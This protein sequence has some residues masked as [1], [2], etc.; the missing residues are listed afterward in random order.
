MKTPTLVALIAASFFVSNLTHA[1]SSTEKPNKEAEKN[2]MF[3]KLDKNQDG[4]ISASEAVDVI[5][6]DEFLKF[7]SNQDGVITQ[8]EYFSEGASKKVSVVVPDDTQ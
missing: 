8:P 6:V 2:T 3:Q 7:D 4:L 5:S 1:G